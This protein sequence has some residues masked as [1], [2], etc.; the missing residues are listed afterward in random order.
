MMEIK[1]S[2]VI[3]ID[4]SKPK[5]ED[6]TKSFIDVLGV[7]VKDFFQKIL[8][9]FAEHYMQ[10]TIKPFSCDRC[11]NN[12][13]FIWKTRHGK[14]TQLY[15]VF[16][17][18]ELLQMQIECKECGHKMYLT[19]KLLDVEPRKRVPLATIRK[20]GLIGALTTYRV[21]HKIVGMFGIVLDKMTVWRCV[22]KLSEQINLEID[23][24]ERAAAEAD[25]TGIPIRGIDK[26]GKEMKVLV[27][28]KKLGG[29]RIAGL[30]IGN[31]DSEW[32]KLFKPLIPV[33]QCF[34]EFLLITDGDTSILK[35]LGDTVKVLF[36][37]CLWHIPHQFKWYLWKDGVKHKSDE[38]KDAFSKLL[39]VVN[40]KSL[41]DDKAKECVENIITVKRM[42]LDALIAICKKNEWK[43]CTTYL[44]N[45]K[46]DLF[47]SLSNRL[48]GKTTSH[49]ERVMRTM[50]MRINVGKWSPQ[51]ALNATKVRLAYYY[52]GFD[53]E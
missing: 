5:L 38:W 21:A 39:D 23:P 20:L 26:R 47:V 19:R 29:V 52:N 43:R 15:T 13:E 49:A 34:K 4:I 9:E 7:L 8:L 22:Q 25:G 45:A 51:G 11:G 17:L 24:Q 27:Q 18:L 32:D 36:Q 2:S 44:E 3:I 37:R 6:I 50:N 14:Q 12:R 1:F 41:T 46:E 40:V 10:E 28:L 31:Y 53:V 30:S 42:H 33:L 35:G 16:G 48:N